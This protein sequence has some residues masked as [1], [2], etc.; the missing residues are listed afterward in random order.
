MKAKPVFLI[1][2]FLY[3][4]GFSIAS[5]DTNTGKPEMILESESKGNVAFPHARHQRTVVDC[6][7]C[8]GLF[9]KEVG[10][11]QNLIKEGKPTIDSI[12]EHNLQIIN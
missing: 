6:S 5:S 7:K 3:I 11:I 2:T 9:P 12:E 10:I 1:I 8:H 4:F